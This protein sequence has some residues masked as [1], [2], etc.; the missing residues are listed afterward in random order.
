MFRK[1]RRPKQEVSAETCRKILQTENRAVL[2]VIGDNGYPY[3]VPVNFVYDA[4]E[5][6]IYLHGA[7][8]GHKIDAIRSCDKV[9]FTTWDKGYRTQ[10][11]W[12]W[13]V[14]SVIVMGRAEFIDDLEIVTEKV[15]K[16]GLKYYPSSDEVEEEIRAAIQAV[17]IIAI[18]I[19]HMTGKQI[20][21]R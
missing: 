21:E 10:G 3:G 11:D 20:Y 16:L 2:S 7:K 17:R 13:H 18:H 6:T 9:C 19:E 4:E 15:R 12:A 1:M 14:T 5:G 8:E